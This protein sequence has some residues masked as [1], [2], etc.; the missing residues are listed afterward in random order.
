[1]RWQPHLTREAYELLVD[2]GQLGPADHVELI[3][4]EIVAAEPQTSR[5]ATGVGLGFDALHSVLS[6]DF[7]VRSK[8][9]LALYPDSEPE[10]DLAVV[11]GSPRDYRDV[12]PTT[13]ALVVEVADTTLAY[14]RETKGGLYACAGLPDYWIVNLVDRVLEVYRQPAPDTAA[15]LGYTYRERLRFGPQDRVSLLSTPEASVLVADLLP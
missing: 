9:P 7:H 11:P 14:D 5:H 1:M 13:A 4:G 12:P 10:P 8:L 2:R 6:A 3:A 15:L